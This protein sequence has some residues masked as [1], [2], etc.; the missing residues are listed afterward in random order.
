MEASLGSSHSKDCSSKNSE[1][2]AA[3]WFSGLNLNNVQVL[4]V[5][6]VGLGFAYGAAE[7]WLREDEFRSLV[8]LEENKQVID[9]LHETEQGVRL[10]QDRQVAVHHISEQLLELNEIVLPYSLFS[11]TVSHLEEYDQH[12]YA[13][14]KSL[15]AFFANYHRSAILG[16]SQGGLYFF[17][18][19]FRNILKLPYS[20][21]STFL[22][23]KFKGIPAIICGAGP[24]LDK[25]IDVLRKLHSRALIFAGATAINALNVNGV[26]PHIG[27]GID[28]N[29]QQLTRLIM[30]QEHE[31]PFFYRNR[32]YHKALDIIH[33]D[34]ICVSGSPG[35]EIA[36]WIEKKLNLET[37][38][39]SEG[40]LSEGYNVLNLALS[41]A[42][43]MGCN[44][45]IMVGV[46]LAYTR[47]LSYASGIQSHPLHDR[48]DNFATKSVEERILD[49]KD[50]YGQPIR[51]LWKWVRE[52]LW[53][54][55]FAQEHPDVLLINATEGGIGF[56]GIQNK[57]LAEAAAQYLIQHFDIRT[58]LHGEI[59]NS[60]WP[61]K[62]D[63]TKIIALLAQLLES[64][65]RCVEKCKQIENE[66]SLFN[67]SIL[68]SRNQEEIQAAINQLIEDLKIEDAYK[69]MLSD[70]EE[71]CLRFTSLERQRLKNEKKIIPEEEVALRQNTLD[72]ILYKLLNKTAYSN[73]LLIETILKD[74]EA[75]RAAMQFQ[76][77][78]LPLPLSPSENEIYLFDG[79]YL[80]LRDPELGLDYSEAFPTDSYLRK[81][82]L[83]YPNGKVKIEQFY[84]GMF[85][86]GPSKF[87]SQEGKMLA[88]A[89]FVHGQQQGKMLTYYLSGQ[90][91]SVQRFRD[92]QKQGK[93]E[94][95]YPDGILKTSLS[96]L[97]GCLHSEIESACRL[98]HPN[99]QLAREQYFIN[100]QLEGVERIWNEYGQLEIEVEYC[101]NRPVNRTRQWHPNGQLACE[102]IYDSHSQRMDAHFWN[103][104]G[105]L[106]SEKESKQESY[107]QILSKQTGNLTQSLEEFLL[108][109][110]NLMPGVIGKDQPDLAEDFKELHREMTRLQELS[111]ALK[112]ESANDNA[113]ECGLDPISQT[114][115]EQQ[116]WQEQQ[117]MTEQM[118]S[119][120]Q[121]LK[122]ILKR[123]SQ[124]N[125]DDQN[126]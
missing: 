60:Q 52:S 66:L 73:F 23:D 96:Y 7:Q 122:D 56:P 64:L 118:Q 30:N 62:I 15:I 102:I 91:H 63:E 35:F 40:P 53:Y 57:T 106:I 92:G 28:P 119:I 70:I 108:N 44:P 47:G 11:F 81:E 67:K 89:W 103:S 61:Q 126:E 34:K 25:N 82:R 9:R 65:K 3:L 98:Y 109:V 80:T 39:G 116:L 93:Q 36:N 41:L 43:D 51:T 4:Y 20:Y 48:R 32:I 78:S 10:L 54:G 114:A 101:H 85:L 68:V 19:Y 76:P 99:G 111:Q 87:F 125:Q 105:T 110:S 72:L 38:I 1:N 107:F 115:F 88:Q 90:A 121:G 86:H 29:P 37:A 112:R 26:V 71:S 22:S 50:I 55:L 84:Q 117:K 94:F 74:H 123:L 120:D 100:G 79:Q 58:R 5:Y 13:E 33:G 16:Y 75:H 69:A 49:K 14:I 24:S 77:K 42:H 104:E 124:N 8:F 95:F 6:G 97:S 31:M 83:F 2:E 21:N 18:N 45:I 59:Q 12:R 46:D 27:V 113:Q 17:N